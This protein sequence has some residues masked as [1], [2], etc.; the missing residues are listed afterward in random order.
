MI[1]LKSG[2]RI[3]ASNSYR[4][5]SSVHLKIDEH[6]NSP[7][8]HAAYQDGLERTLTKHFTVEKSIGGTQCFY[9][10]RVDGTKEDF[11][12]GKCLKG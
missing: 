7:S 9:I 4:T 8:N 5:F 1:E 3:W 10:T 6:L 11:S 12:F 2:T